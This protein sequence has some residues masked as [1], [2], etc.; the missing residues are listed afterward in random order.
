MPNAIF[1]D[2]GKDGI[3]RYFR[4]MVHKKRNWRVGLHPR[5]IAAR[6]CLCAASSR[7]LP[8]RMRKDLLRPARGDEQEG[9][10]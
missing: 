10:R 8:R 2:D 3:K 4:R 5:R 1:A 9:C 6:T 7:L